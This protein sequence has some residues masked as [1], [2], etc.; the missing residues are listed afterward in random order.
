MWVTSSAERMAITPRAMEDRGYADTTQTKPANRMAAD[1]NK[2]S[3]HVHRIGYHFQSGVLEQAVADLNYTV[4]KGRFVKEEDLAKRRQENLTAQILLKH[5]VKMNEMGSQES[6]EQVRAAIKEL[7]P[8]IP[9]EDLE[10]IVK[11]AWEE[12]TGRVGSAQALDL[13]RRVQLA[14][15]ARIRHKYTDYDRLLRAFE[16]KDA[17][18]MTEPVSLQKLIEWRG[19]QDT[20]EDDQLEEMVRETIVIDDDDESVTLVNGSEADDEDSAAEQGDNSDASIEVIN[21]LADDTDIGG[22]STYEGPQHPLRRFQPVPRRSQ[23]LQKQNVARQKLAEAYQRRRALATGAAPTSSAQQGGQQSLVLTD[24]G[25]IETVYL[26]PGANGGAFQ[27]DGNTYQPVGRQVSD[28]SIVPCTY[29]IQIPPAPGSSTAQQPARPQQAI[30]ASQHAPQTSPTGDV[31][32]G[33]NM[34]YQ[35][36]AQDRPVA[37]IER[38]NGYSVVS[39]GNAR[40]AVPRHGLMHHHPITPERD[41]PS[42]RRRVDQSSLHGPPSSSRSATPSGKVVDLTTPEQPPRRRFMPLHGEV[43]DLMT[44]EPPYQPYHPSPLR[45]AR[46]VPVHSGRAGQQ[47]RYE[48]FQ[49][50]S[51]LRQP[52]PMRFNPPGQTHTKDN[53]AVEDLAYDPRQPMLQLPQQVDRLSI[54]PEQNRRSPFNGMPGAWPV[55]P[56]HPPHQPPPQPRQYYEVPHQPMYTQ[57]PQPQPSF[58]YPSAA[59]PRLVY[60]QQQPSRPTPQPIHGAPA[61]VQVVPRY[62]PYQGHGRPPT[63]PPP[64]PP[65]DGAPAPVQVIP[66]LAPYSGYG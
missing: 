1:P 4:Y 33:P 16:W 38:N 47:P 62:A 21:H 9:T 51:A 60:E 57:Y 32:Y 11:H 59:P 19:E 30:H 44:P 66:R 42:K 39:Q 46:M 53:I 15:I 27:M 52:S 13:S 55:S 56:A 23:R 22:E 5:G 8:K 28:E 17:R 26:P 10:G 65:T 3:H 37:S 36:R 6:H 25:N 49:S 48:Q 35:P 64:Q 20:E 50:A 45:E 24:D 31:T 61:P 7:F 43:V 14:V 63:V 34:R 2:L 29:G 40:Q 58:A 54:R 18:Q 41:P 12:G